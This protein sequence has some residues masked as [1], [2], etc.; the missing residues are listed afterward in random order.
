MRDDRQLVKKIE[1]AH[2]C[3]AFLMPPPAAT[4]DR[5][6]SFSFGLLQRF[7]VLLPPPS[8]PLSSSRVSRKAADH[9]IVFSESRLRAWTTLSC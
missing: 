9:R 1:G 2:V 6:P 3:H 7:S 5:T 8:F 4:A